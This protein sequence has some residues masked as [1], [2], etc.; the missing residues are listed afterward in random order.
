MPEVP[1]IWCYGRGKPAG[2]RALPSVPRDGASEVF[3]GSTLP[4]PKTGSKTP[5][6]QGPE[7]SWALGL[8]ERRSM[9]LSAAWQC[10]GQPWAAKG[11]PF[12]EHGAPE[13]RSSQESDSNPRTWRCGAPSLGKRRWV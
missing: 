13:H 7:D 11:Q 3:A 6:W 8:Q 1:G 4:N 5:P 10:R 12:L 2:A 9:A